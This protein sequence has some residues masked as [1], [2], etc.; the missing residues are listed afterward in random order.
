MSAIISLIV[1]VLII[2]IY[3][4]V[5]SKS[6]QQV[7]SPNRN[8]LVFENRNKSYGAYSLRKEY[9][10]RMMIIT[11][12]LL[13]F[14]A[15]IYSAWI[16][17]KSIPEIVPPTPPVDTTQIT[18]PAP[19]IEEAPP[20]PPE[21]V[22]PPVEETV[23]FM[24]P[25]VVDIPVEEEVP[26]QE[27]MVDKK[28]DTET[29]ES[30]GDEFAPPEEETGPPIL[31]QKEAEPETF[32]DEEAEFPGGYQGMMA[33]IQKNLVYPETAIENNVQGK[34]FLRF[35]VSVSGTISNV[36]VTKG[37]PDCPECDKAAVKAIRAMPNWKPGKLNG[38]SVSS[39]CSIPINFAIE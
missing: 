33:F 25:I 30:V 39:Y 36:T 14:I 27:E 1:L 7:S 20:P 19:P 9:D 8:D 23:A 13:L 6:W 22:P 28:A 16:I 3:D 17:Y 38:R 18:V 12:S 31:E 2:T 29:K 11:F 26:I 32:V 35:V 10:K 5:S 24:P 4:Y 37:V 34:C 21:D 15:L